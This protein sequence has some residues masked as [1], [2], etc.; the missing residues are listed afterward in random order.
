M[1]IV[2]KKSTQNQ[3]YTFVFVHFL[4]EMSIFALIPM[5]R[6]FSAVLSFQ[7][8]QLCS[9]NIF[10]SKQTIPLVEKKC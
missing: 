2:K 6:S 9:N 4:C 8:V 5:Y 3:R 7:R 10:L 1:W